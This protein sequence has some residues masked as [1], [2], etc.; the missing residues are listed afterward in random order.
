MN[1][2]TRA[3]LRFVS[4]I[5]IGAGFGILAAGILGVWS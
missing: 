1:P 2:Q 5:L 4:Y 3:T